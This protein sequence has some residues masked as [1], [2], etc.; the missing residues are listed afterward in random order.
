[1]HEDCADFPYLHG[2]SPDEQD[3][4]VRQ[5]RLAESTVFHHAALGGARRLLE[6]GSAGGAQTGIL[7]RRF[8]GLHVTCVDP[9]DAQL[10]AA[11][12]NLGSRPWLADRYAL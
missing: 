2:F 7:R 11:R 8:P 5:A 3:R 6:A 12:A 4:L 9:T 1:M 10:S